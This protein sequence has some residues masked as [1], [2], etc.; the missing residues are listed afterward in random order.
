MALVANLTDEQP[1]STQRR[2]VDTIFL[3]FQESSLELNN[4]KT[5]KLCYN[6]RWAPDT[7]HLL[8]GPLRLEGQVVEQVKI[9][10]TEINHHLSF[11]QHADRVYKKAPVHVS[12][13]EP[14]RF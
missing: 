7:T 2:Y 8:S 12:P 11:A 3:L 1:L 9:L 14:E 13:E 6:G 4:S 5:K 10:G